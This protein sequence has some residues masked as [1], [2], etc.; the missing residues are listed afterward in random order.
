MDWVRNPETGLMKII[1]SHHIHC[2]E[3]GAII[4]ISHNEWAICDK[5]GR[6]Y[7]DIIADLA[8]E[9]LQNRRKIAMSRFV[10]SLNY[11]KMAQ[12]VP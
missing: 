8:A 4:R 5:C 12:A 10:K 1:G 2:K 7:N 11:D 3:C 6:I 9:D